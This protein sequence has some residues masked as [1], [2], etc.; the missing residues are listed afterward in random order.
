MNVIGDTTAAG[1]SARTQP[2][3]RLFLPNV[4]RRLGGAD[5][6]STP[7]VLQTITA[8]SLKISWYR[9]ADGSLAVA[10]ELPVTPK[11]SIR[12]DPRDVLGLADETQ[13]AVVVDAIGGTATGIVVELNFQGGDGAMIY[14]GFAR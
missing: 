11:Q 1:Y 13:Y 6:W 12:I 2:A 9:F 14:E 5:G 7:L 4:T 10:Q 3:T 8:T